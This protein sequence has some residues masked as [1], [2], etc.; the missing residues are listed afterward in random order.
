MPNK[1][2]QNSSENTSKI[3]KDVVVELGIDMLEESPNNPYKVKDDEKMMETANSVIEHGVLVPLIVRKRDNGKFQIVSGHR[4]KR[5]CELAEISKLPCIVKELTD[6]EATIIMVDSNIQRDN[7]LPS[8]RAFAYRM[9]LEAM[10]HQGKKEEITSAT[11]VQKFENTS[12]Q[13]LAELFGVS[14]EQIRKYIRLTY[15]VPEILEMVDIGRIALK[16]AV[17]IS[18]LTE[19]EQRT[20]LKEMKYFLATPSES[21]AKRLKELSETGKLNDDMIADIISTPKSNQVEKYEIVY[22]S[23][24]DYLPDKVDTPR[25]VSDYLLKCLIF[26]NRHRINVDKEVA[27][28]VHGK[29][30]S[31]PREIE[32]R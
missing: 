29:T 6:D 11:L 14:R 12:R 24:R 32:E 3:E 26:C 30:K 22:Q 28:P 25:A 7:L 5:A 9:R 4:R 13:K 31:K 10:K 8:E 15:L 23:F 17:Y 21:Q 27:I 2:S 16:P 18:Y 20:L 19:K 1:N